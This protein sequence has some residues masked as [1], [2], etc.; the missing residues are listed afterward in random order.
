MA[1]VPFGT[2]LAAFLMICIYTFLYKEN[3]VYR[4]AEHAMVGAAAGYYFITNLNFIM[5]S[6]VGP[7]LSGRP[8]Y[9]LA[10]ALGSLLFTNLIPKYA[11]L[12]R[13]ALALITGSGIALAVSTVII[14]NAIRQVEGAVAPILTASS[15]GDWI[16]VIVS[17]LITM[18]VV[19]YFT[20]TSKVRPKKLDKLQFIGR[21]GLMV[22][23]GVGYGQ[24]TSYRLNLIIGRV[25]ALL[26]PSI[27]MYSIAFAVILMAIVLYWDYTKNKN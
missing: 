14:T 2:I 22:S 13:Y 21:L 20:Y 4:I 5:K 18:T 27:R 26:E 12:S 25:D 17:V 23:F 10:L 1:A 8:H 19:Y 3:P 7:A 9:F 24:T 16:N 6:G 11:W 15:A